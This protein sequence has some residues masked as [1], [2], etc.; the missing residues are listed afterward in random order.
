VCRDDLPAALDVLARRD[1]GASMVDRVVALEDV[2]DRGLRPLAAGEV[3]GK[4]LVDPRG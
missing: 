3:S 1:L 4:V 2:V